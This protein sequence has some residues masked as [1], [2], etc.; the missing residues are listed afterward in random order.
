[1]TQYL[2]EMSQMKKLYNH[3]LSHLVTN[4]K[5]L[6]GELRTFFFLSLI[7]GSNNFNSKTP[8]QVPWNQ[9]TVNNAEIFY[10]NK[11]NIHVWPMPILLK[12]RDCMIMITVWWV[13]LNKLAQEAYCVPQV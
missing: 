9:E 5:Y 7:K 11:A 2:T 12:W 6:E 1:M 13:E 10:A 4:K 8:L 3:G